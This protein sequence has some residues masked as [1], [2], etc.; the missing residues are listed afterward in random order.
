M[1]QVTLTLN[2]R[3]YCVGCGDGEE[4]RLNELGAHLREKLDAL[5][6]EFGQVGEARL[7]LL[8]SLLI[9][10]ELFD[11]RAEM[12]AGTASTSSAAALREMASRVK[13][14]TK[15]GQSP[16]API[17]PT[18]EPD[19]AATAKPEEKPALSSLQ[20]AMSRQ[21]TAQVAVSANPDTRKTG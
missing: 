2:G 16:P 9:T 17:A 20:S 18:N 5:A 14:E 1:G 21:T 8:A 3:S 6:A 13:V 15:V 11:A 10:D 19:A 12:I 4:A 7:L